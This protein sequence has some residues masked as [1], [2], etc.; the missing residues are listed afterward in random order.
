MFGELD[1]PRIS[2][3]PERR[4]TR[5]QTHGPNFYGTMFISPQDQLNWHRQA[6][7]ISALKLLLG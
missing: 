6:V 4:A 5:L 3:M 2:K 7:N 1:Y